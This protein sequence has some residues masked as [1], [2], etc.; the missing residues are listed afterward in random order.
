MQWYHYLLVLLKLIFLIE[1]LFVLYD[2]QLV[3]RKIYIT[4][5]ILFKLLLSIYIQYVIVFVIYKNI[6]LED[7]FFISFGSGLLMYDAVFND[8]PVLLELYGI[9]NTSLVH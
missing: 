8:L 2:K 7:R 5:E 9:Y 4:S 1:F 3:S 6:S